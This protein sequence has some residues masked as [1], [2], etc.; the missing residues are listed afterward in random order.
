MT[1]LN[2]ISEDGE[3]FDFNVLSTN[4]D[5]HLGG[6]DFDKKICDYCI[7]KFCATF[8]NLNENDIKNDT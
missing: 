1:L 6:D 4:G 5:P 2:I 8:G 3:A 7:R